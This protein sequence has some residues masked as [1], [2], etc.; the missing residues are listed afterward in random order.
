MLC[1]TVSV[2][3]DVSAPDPPVLAGE[4]CGVCDR[5]R[6]DD[7]VDAALVPEGQPPSMAVDD[8]KVDGTTD[9][10]APAGTAIPI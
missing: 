2:I 4:R 3:P 10:S 5:L 6:N 8:S 1:P 7:P 9:R